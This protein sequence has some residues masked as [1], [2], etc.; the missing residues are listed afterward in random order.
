MV[1]LLSSAAVALEARWVPVQDARKI[2]GWWILL[3]LGS[4]VKCPEKAEACGE[5]PASDL[6][7]SAA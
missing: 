6:Q 7:A 2:G 1:P 5:G 3:V 4:W